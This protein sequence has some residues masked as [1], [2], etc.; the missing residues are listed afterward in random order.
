M[1]VK[2]YTPLLRPMLIRF[3]FPE[4][5]GFT[6]D[7]LT[8]FI[9][10]LSVFDSFGDDR[11]Y[12][13]NSLLNPEEG[14][15]YREGI[16]TLSTCPEKNPFH[17]NDNLHLGTLDST[18]EEAI[19]FA[20]DL[21]TQLKEKYP[22]LNPSICYSFGDQD[23]ISEVFIEPLDLEMTPAT[24]LAPADATAPAS[25]GDLTDDGNI[26]IMD[27]ILLNK[28]IYGKSELTEAQAAAADVN[29]DGKPDAADSL[30]IM[31]HI[32]KLIDS[33]Q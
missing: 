2:E 3:E 24:Y 15:F 12:V 4:S 11:L 6:V 10:E 13:E 7:N 9:P 29:Q 25:F 17:K 27:V 16:F 26:N 31:K 19:A 28:A 23:G 22:D 5:Y 14:T 8:E 18:P 33:F 30:L 20:T 1:Q 32:L 21:E